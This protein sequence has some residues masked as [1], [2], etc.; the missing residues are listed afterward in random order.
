M[1]LSPLFEQILDQPV[2]HVKISY[3]KGA[4]LLKGISFSQQR[5]KESPLYVCHS[6]YV[7]QMELFQHMN[8]L[9]IFNPKQFG[10][11]SQIRSSHIFLLPRL[12]INKR[13]TLDER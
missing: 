4:S 3:L 7:Y 11:E 5:C 8:Y 6:S 13:R 10:P 9:L 12:D 1:G 2:G